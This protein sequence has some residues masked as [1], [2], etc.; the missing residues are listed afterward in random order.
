MPRTVVE[1]EWGDAFD[2]FGF[3]D[4][5]GWNG[6][7]IVASSIDALGYNTECDGWGCHNYLIVDIEKDGK[8]ILFDNNQEWNAETLKRIQARGGGE[9]YSEHIGYADPNL[10]LPDDILEMLN[11]TFTDDYEVAA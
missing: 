7:H 1:W 4:G 11:A 6:T 3:C 9:S 8:S 2:K 10:Y 5:D